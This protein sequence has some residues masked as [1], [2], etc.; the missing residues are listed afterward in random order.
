MYAIVSVYPHTGR[1]CSG[2]PKN[3]DLY[4]SFAHTKNGAVTALSPH[5]DI[6]LS[7]GTK[8]AHN[9]SAWALSL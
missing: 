5:M 1:A 2:T 4:I 9:L 3:K 6:A 7:D 8:N